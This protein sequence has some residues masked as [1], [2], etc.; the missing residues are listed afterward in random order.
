MKA[1]VRIAVLFVL[2]LAPVAFADEVFSVPVTLQPGVTADVAVHVY[3]NPHRV[4]PALDVVIIHGLAQ[5]GVSMAPLANA[6]FADSMGN[7]VG[8][9]IVIDLP[10]HGQSS[11]P[12]GMQFGQLAIEHYVVA[13][14][15]VL[16]ALPSHGMSSDVL[17]GHSMG[18]VIIQI[19]Q[20][21]LLQQGTTLRAL[22]GVRGAVLIAPVLPYNEPWGFT[23]QAQAVLGGTIQFDPTLGLYA[24][25][26]LP[27]WYFLFYS[28]HFGAIVPNAPSVADAL[29]YI[30]Y[31][32]FVAGA[33]VVRLAPSTPVRAGA[34]AASNGTQLAVLNLERDGLFTADEHR[35][36][37]ELL[38]G[39]GSDKQ[40]F[41]VTGSD[42]VH[43]VHTIDP[44]ILLH[45]IKKLINATDRN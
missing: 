43:S 29:T 30:S 33:Q 2:V 21:L 34:F 35:S 1:I 31:E 16:A 8:R 23:V 6:L 40:F 22:D 25:I 13:V 15:G 9:A 38:T 39:D 32:S 11:L 7:K 45:P 28:D 10:G 42:A 14:L 20:E 19:A 4:P 18:G 26:P 12:N 5:T 27:L 17:I 24:N 36:L 44:D 3:E 37:Y 41:A